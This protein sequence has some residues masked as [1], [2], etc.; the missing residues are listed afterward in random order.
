MRSGT[1]PPLSRDNSDD[2]AAARLIQFLRRDLLEFRK[3]GEETFASMRASGP[4]SER[5][6]AR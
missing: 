1:S 6:A 2:V 3:E 4:R 5:F